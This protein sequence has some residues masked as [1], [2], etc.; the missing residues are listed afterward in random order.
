MSA[1]PEVKAT[2][3]PSCS[4]RGPGS[5]A[6][7][8]LAGS[9]SA[10]W[11]AA[12]RPGWRRAA[13]GSAGSCAWCGQLAVEGHSAL[14]EVVADEHQLQPN[15]AGGEP[16]KGLAVHAGVAQGFEDVLHPGVAAL[17][18]L[19]PQDLAHGVGEG[20]L[21]AGPVGVPH[22]Q[23]GGLLPSA[24]GPGPWW[25][26]GDADIELGHLASVAQLTFAVDGLSP[27]AGRH[28]PDR[29]A[30]LL[31]QPGAD[32]EPDVAGHLSLGGGHIVGGIGADQHGTD[33]IVGGVTAVVA[34]PV[35]GWQLGD[36][37]LYHRQLVG[38]GVGVGVAGANDAGQGLA[39]VIVELEHGVE[40]EAALEMAGGGFIDLRVHLDQRRV[41]ARTIWSDAFTAAPHRGPGLGASPPRAVGD[42][43]VDLDHGPPD[44]RL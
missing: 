20:D 6:R 44:G 42:L 8:P 2:C 32:G 23:L 36:G 7:G 3:R 15:L 12:A 29:C 30:E 34:G 22:S 35:L 28:R 11:R 31:G 27:G 17:A 4:I 14:Q 21:V 13:A 10:T 16:A 18:Q 39:G 26:S 38:G 5:P 37:Q 43:V 9:R 33:D 19:R 41:D 40:A 24:D 25:P 1:R